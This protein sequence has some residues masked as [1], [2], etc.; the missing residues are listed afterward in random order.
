MEK[1]KLDRTFYRA[2]YIPLDELYN[3]Q[4][5]KE[6]IIEFKTASNDQDQEFINMINLLAILVNMNFEQTGTLLSSHFSCY[7]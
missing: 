3:E 2:M 5:L 1:V 4:E 7:N 6:L